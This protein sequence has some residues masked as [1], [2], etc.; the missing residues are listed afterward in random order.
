MY[1]GTVNERVRPYIEAAIIAHNQLD[2]SFSLENYASARKEWGKDFKNGELPPEIQIYFEFVEAQVYD[3]IGQDMIAFSKYYLS[4][5][6][7]DKIGFDKPD[8]ALPF[9]GMGGC[10]FA[11]EEYDMSLRCYLKA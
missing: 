4:K 3:S 2:Y 11:M 10:L 5:G 6:L 9:C 7:A 1:P 8:R